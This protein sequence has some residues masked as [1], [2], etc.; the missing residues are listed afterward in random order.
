MGTKHGHGLAQS[1]RRGT[2]YHLRHHGTI[3]Y[4][5]CQSHTQPQMQPGLN[6]NQVL[7][8]D[9]ASIFYVF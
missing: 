3:K 9:W 8:I 5:N 6:F 7:S 4:L 2:H 1:L